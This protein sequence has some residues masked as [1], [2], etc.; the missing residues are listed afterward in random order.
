MPLASPN[1]SISEGVASGALASACHAGRER[2]VPVPAGSRHTLPSRRPPPAL[3]GRR[4]L[5]AVIGSPPRRRTLPE[6]AT[7]GP[8]QPARSDEDAQNRPSHSAHRSGHDRRRPQ[9]VAPGMVVGCLLRR[10]LRTS[11]G[12]AG[13]PGADISE[14]AS[15]TDGGPSAPR[16]VH[17]VCGPWGCERGASALAA[18]LSQW[19]IRPPR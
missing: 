2:T 14:D 17:P 8:S 13:A 9:A 11:A 6:P 3:P 7:S 19:R 15:A 5:Y 12:L 4:A 10:S 1:N 18:G 16:P